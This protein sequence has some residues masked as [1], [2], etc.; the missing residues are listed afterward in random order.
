MVALVKMSSAFSFT[1][2]VATRSLTPVYLQKEAL[3]Q[4]FP[5]IM[6]GKEHSNTQRRILFT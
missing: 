6:Q 4:K 5:Q 3:I 1:Y 2:L